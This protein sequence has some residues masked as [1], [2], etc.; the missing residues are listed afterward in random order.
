M[1]S[2][3][4]T[5]KRTYFLVVHFFT[6]TAMWLF[7]FAA[8][9]VSAQSV[10][11]DATF[12]LQSQVLR[13]HMF[14]NQSVVPDSYLQ[15]PSFKGVDCPHN[16]LPNQPQDASSAESCC[17][18]C[19]STSGCNG[20]VFKSGGDCYLKN[21]CQVP[22]TTGLFGGSDVVSSGPIY[23]KNTAG[24]WCPAISG[25]NCPFND[26]PNQPI[27]NPGSAG[28]CCDA[29]HANGLCNGFV[30]NTQGQCWLK[31][32]C[33]NPV[34]GAGDVIASGPIRRVNAKG[35]V[36]PAIRQLN[37]WGND[38][39]K[40]TGLS[41]AGECCD[42]CHATEG[43]RGIVYNTQRECYLKHQCDNPT[44]RADDV[45]AS[46]PIER[47]P[48]G[49][50]PPAPVPPPV[51]PPSA[52]SDAQPKCLGVTCNN[53]LWECGDWQGP[54][55]CSA[56]MPKCLGVAC[57]DG[58]WMCGGDWCPG[59]DSPGG[60]TEVTDA[61][62]LDAD[63]GF[64]PDFSCT[65][66]EMYCSSDSGDGLTVGGCCPT[67]CKKEFENK[68]KN[69]NA[70]SKSKNE[71]ERKSKRASDEASR[72]KDEKQRKRDQKE[73]EW[74]SKRDATETKNKNAEEER[75]NKRGWKEGQRKNERGWKKN[76][77][78]RQAA[79]D[80]RERARKETRN[81]N[82]KPISKE[83]ANNKAKYAKCKAKPK[84]EKEFKKKGR[85]EPTC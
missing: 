66:T 62:C 47:L 27:P 15:C 11:D 42:A 10:D 2:L 53:G 25:L 51:P 17:S 39:A 64:G 5:K 76:K 21:A 71:A 59:T 81:K 29:C 44:L 20:Y 36:C 54:A 52:C 19:H 13:G 63:R 43:C 6:F 67:K 69:S 84:C 48:A 16:D 50:K 22:K 32:G 28:A 74:N 70:E 31:N 85:K 26:L 46:G 7:S 40:K 83:C 78:E 45:I 23:K 35:L 65:N 3:S 8:V 58:Q 55:L 1:I 60:E 9:V 14:Q 75:K 56:N 77:Q 37:C 38:I 72:K 12:L 18:R 34:T 57:V 73:T 68:K 49:W 80:Q 33:E 24:N 61:D 30:Y 79:A 4:Q 82:Q 41:S